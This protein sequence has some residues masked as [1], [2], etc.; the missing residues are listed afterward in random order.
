MSDLN[1]T[2]PLDALPPTRR[3]QRALADLGPEP[4]IIDVEE[5]PLVSCA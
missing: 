3:I 2:D 4:E 1:L 5:A